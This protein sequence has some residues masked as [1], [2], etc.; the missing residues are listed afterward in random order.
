M[1]GLRGTSRIDEDDPILRLKMRTMGVAVDNGV[2]SGGGRI[3][4]ESANVMK[5]KKVDLFDGD[6]I[7]GR[8]FVRPVTPVHISPHR[9]D[10]R[11]ILQNHENVRSI[12][13][14]GVNDHIDPLQRFD[15]MRIEISV[16]I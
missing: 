15:S 16:G 5:D 7:C 14:A 13:V 9:T 2:N 1:T 3:E 6:E 11:H 4:V 8:Q 12:D 10:R